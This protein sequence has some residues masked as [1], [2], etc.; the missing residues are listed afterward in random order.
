M[1]K[2]VCCVTMITF[3]FHVLILCLVPL[4]FQQLFLPSI[5]LS[6]CWHVHSYSTSTSRQYLYMFLYAL[7][8]VFHALSIFRTPVNSSQLQ[9]KPFNVVCSA[10]I[11]DHFPFAASFLFFFSSMLQASFIHCRLLFHLCV[12][13]W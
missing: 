6:L 2:Y 9:L 4:H 7:C 11:L 5:S 3:R 10:C 8:Y 13:W 1:P 12:V